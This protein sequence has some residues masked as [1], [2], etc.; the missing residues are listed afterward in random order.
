VDSVTSFVLGVCAG[1][2][3]SVVAWYVPNRMLV[4]RWRV[5]GKHVRTDRNGC[6]RDSFLVANDGFRDIVDA[7]ISCTMFST[8]WGD[9]KRSLRSAVT[10]P[11][12][13]GQI[14]FMPGRGFLRRGREQYGPRVVMIKPEDITEFQL[15]KLSEEQRER[16]QQGG[17]DLAELCRW[18]DESQVIIAVYGVDGF[19]GTRRVSQFPLATD[20]ASP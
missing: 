1:I 2:A 19:S 20:N 3:T 9:G 11:V 12:T 8:G 18:G 14:D 16:V 10:I 4:P 15:S 5:Y 7:S 13:K 17:V 6:K